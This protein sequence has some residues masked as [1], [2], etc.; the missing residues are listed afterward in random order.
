MPKIEINELDLTT[1][2]VASESTDVVYIPGFVNIDQDCLYTN[3]STDPKTFVRGDYIGLKAFKPHLFTSVAE[4]NSLCGK[5]APTFAEDQLYS[6]LGIDKFDSNAIPEDGI[7]FEEGTADPSYVMAKELLAAGISVLYE[8]VNETSGETETYNQV[9]GATATEIAKKTNDGSISTYYYKDANGDY[10][11]YSTPNSITAPAFPTTKSDL[12]AYSI[13]SVSIDTL[14]QEKWA[15]KVTGTNV[16]Y[17]NTLYQLN[18]DNK[19]ESVFKTSN[20]GSNPTLEKYKTD[21]P[22]VKTFYTFVQLTSKPADWD[23]SYSNYAKKVGND[24]VAYVASATL[25]TKF[26]A[27]NI[28]TQYMKDAISHATM[29]DAFSAADQWSEFNIEISDL[30]GV[31]ES[32]MSADCINVFFVGDNLMVKATSE[33]VDMRIYDSLGRQCLNIAPKCNELSI[34]ASAWDCHIYIAKIVLVSGETLTMKIA[35]R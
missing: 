14:T 24:F 10:I 27:K 16:V 19:Y 33:I 3:K 2:G 34:D 32:E 8:R 28:Y 35:R 18:G 23:T 25:Y 30:T 1:P 11:N 17:C 6:D 9:T 15:E 22:D 13:V 5:V 26:D 29:Y 20:D 12:D 7:M 31:L 21:N 4:F